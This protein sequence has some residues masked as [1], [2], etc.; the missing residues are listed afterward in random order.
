MMYVPVC[1]TNTNKKGLF[2][3]A[4]DISPFFRMSQ[5]TVDVQKMDV[6]DSEH[7]YSEN[8]FRVLNIF[9]SE[10]AKK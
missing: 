8:M 9:D 7:V 6:Q 4:S 2:A 5:F 1:A 3:K 10:H